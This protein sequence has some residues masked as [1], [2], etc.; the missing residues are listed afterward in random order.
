MSNRKRMKVVSKKNT[1]HGS[2]VARAG[3]SLGTYIIS[4]FHILSR[5]NEI[6]IVFALMIINNLLRIVWNSMYVTLCRTHI[7]GISILPKFWNSERS[8]LFEQWIFKPWSVICKTKSLAQ[9]K[10]VSRTNY[11]RCFKE[12]TFKVIV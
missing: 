12:A 11:H 4:G 6:E 1:T 7:D 3:I 10:K 2:T 5:K 9:S 8:R